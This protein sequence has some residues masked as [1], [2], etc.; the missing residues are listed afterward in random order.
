MAAVLRA[1]SMP[2]L[3]AR[4]RRN[5]S[6]HAP[7]VHK[8]R[9]TQDELVKALRA[10]L[11]TNAAAGRFAGTVLFARIGGDTHAAPM[12]LFSGAYGLAD[13]DKN[14]ANTM[15]TRFRIRSMTE[16]FTAVAILQLVEAGKIRLD[17]PLGKYIPDYPNQEIAKKVTVDQLRTHTGGTGDIS[18]AGFTAHRLDL[19]TLDDYATLYGKRAPLFEPGSRWEY[20]NYGMLLLGVVIQRVTGQ[21]YYDYVADHVDGPAGMARSG[22]DPEN[23]AV[24]DRSVGYIWQ[25]GAKGTVP[26]RNTLPYRGTS[27]GGGYS[28]VGTY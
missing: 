7:R 26:N 28:I 11:A 24:P 1:P 17:D 12:V 18:G 19:K 20:S 14:V 15:D 27:A 22:S 9:M 21:T 25:L 4:Y 6:L 5:G 16:M 2:A 23:E 13:R 3:V 10:R 8:T